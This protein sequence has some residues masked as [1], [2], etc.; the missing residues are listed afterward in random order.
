MSFQCSNLFFRGQRKCV[1]MGRGNGKNVEHVRTL[2]IMRHV[3]TDLRFVKKF[4]RPDFWAKKF[5]TLKVH[6][7]R[8]FPLKKKE[9]K[10]IDFS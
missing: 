8:L 2:Y 4:T 10:C 9:C 6:K 1:G 5:Y 7:L 3:H